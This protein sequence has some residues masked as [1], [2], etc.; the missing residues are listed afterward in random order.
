ME[1]VS[2][3]EGVRAVIADCLHAAVE[4]ILTPSISQIGPINTVGCFLLKHLT[5]VNYL[6]VAGSVEV[7]CAGER[8][9]IKADIENLESHHYYVWIEG[10]HGERGI[11][12]I[13]FGSRYW[14]DWAD[15]AAVAWAGEAPP[16]YVW[17]PARD[18]C[19]R[20]ARYSA[21]GEITQIVRKGIA[22]A[23]NADG[24][25]SAAAWETA[26][27][28]A[29]DGIMN[30]PCGL[31]YLVDQGIACPIDDKDSHTGRGEPC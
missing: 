22:E 4:T 2:P 26:I 24:N 19:A 25:P 23:I 16:P 5:K 20:V 27:N 30:D 28:E 3:A 13:D 11:E 18:V 21:H 14:R 17:G 31:A 6:P 8:L 10:D 7:L 1:F 15:Q 9:G 12:L 29:I